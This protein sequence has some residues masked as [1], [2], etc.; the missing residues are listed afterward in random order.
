MVNT[1]VPHIMRTFFPYN[2]VYVCTR[3]RVWGNICSPSYIYIV[4]QMPFVCI[5]MINGR[6][7]TPWPCNL[8]SSTMGVIVRFFII[9]FVRRRN[10]Q[11]PHPFQICHF[12]FKLLYFLFLIRI[13][14]FVNYCSNLI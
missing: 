14:I 12:G 8:Q 3:A 10:W 2:I 4:V 9:S 1:S 13:K 6:I 5:N 11:N 7:A